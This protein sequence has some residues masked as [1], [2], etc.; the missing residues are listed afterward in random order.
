MVRKRN[1]SIADRLEVRL[2][3]GSLDLQTQN[4]GRAGARHTFLDQQTKCMVERSA[5]SGWGCRENAVSR[6]NHS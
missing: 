1:T 5:R 3:R 6:E 2:G 4:V